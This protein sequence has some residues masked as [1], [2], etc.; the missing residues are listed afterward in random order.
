MNNTIKKICDDIYLI[1]LPLPF[2][3]VKQ[4]SIY[5]I[6]GSNPAL[7]DTGLGDAESINSISDLLKKINRNIADISYIINTHEHIE[8]FSGN[9]KVKQACGGCTIASSIAAVFIENFSRATDELKTNLPLC[10]PELTEEI[11]DIIHRESKLDIIEIEKKIE[12]DDIIDTGN[13]KLKVISTPGHAKGHICLY[14]EDRK[15]LFTGDH[16]LSKQSTFVG[17][18]FREIISHRITDVFNNING[19]YDNLSLYINSITRLE[20]LDID[21][22]L[23]GHGAPIKDPYKKMA[24]EIKKKERR[25]KLFYKVL[26]RE[27]EIAL[28]KLTQEIY[29]KNNDGFLHMGST[30][31]Y[32][33]RMNRHGIIKVKMK[34][35]EPF[36][37]LKDNFP[38]TNIL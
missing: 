32:L 30:L 20:S 34:G 37:I 25:S 26:N 18:D 29:G 22:I 28:K 36:I 27:K 2:S 10:D 6:D 15:L 1:S 19:E 7:I 24:M 11:N 33:A 9:K 31:G 8:H 4:L 13:V 23:P 38:E 12:D 5:F 35:N 14:D 3:A 17:Y 16:I 21:L